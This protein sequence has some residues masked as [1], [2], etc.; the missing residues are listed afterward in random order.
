MENKNNPSI[1]PLQARGFYSLF[2]GES[3]NFAGRLL[4]PEWDAP[5]EIAAKEETWRIPSPLL[6]S[7][8]LLGGFHS[9]AAPKT[10]LGIYI[11]V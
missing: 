5:A 7:C 10:G 6:L 2:K 11:Q 4:S 8:F 3:C 1:T 9:P